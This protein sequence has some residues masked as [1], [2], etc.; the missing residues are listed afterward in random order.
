MNVTQPT[1]TV[2]S[3][4]E[5]ESDSPGMFASL[6]VRDFRYLWF[7][8]LAATFAMQMQMVARGWLI[9]DMTNSPLALTWVMLSFM[10]PMFLFSLAGG[11]IADRARKKWVMISA[12]VL[13]SVVT[14]ALA[15]IIYMGDVTFWHFIYFGVFN[16]TVLAVSMP[17]RSSIIPEIV[18]RETLVNA[19]AL[20]S[21]TF[22]LSR[23]LGPTLAG[24]LIAIV[25][26]GDTSSMRGVGIVYFTIA[27][28]YVLSVASTA[29]MH[30][31]GA[32]TT[33]PGKSMRGDIAE[34]FRYMR[35]ERL[36]LG[37]LILGFVPMT[38]GFTASFLLPA[39]N[40]DIIGGG[41]D[42]LGLL[43]TAMG[44]GALIGSLVLARVGDIGNKGRVM[45]VTAYLWAV[46]LAAFALSESL[47]TAMIFG[48]F[49]GLFGAIFGSLNMSIVQLA[50]RPEIRGRVMSIMMMAHGLMPIGVIPVSAAAE[51]I[52][53]DVALLGAAF[54]LALSMLALG[55]IFPELNKIDK[56]HDG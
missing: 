20:Q 26:S 8:N 27:G 4:Q 32:P 54:M 5:E 28:L 41:P 49:T 23:V 19:M 13:N 38:F 36:I 24:V 56:G 51:F 34:G 9:Y 50:I 48:A 53:I 22:N 35:E 30:Y 42:D 55:V 10:L 46:F 14:L 6:A 40:K 3:A 47:I 7:S 31:I 29:M 17:A 37:L 15:V 44:A 12:Q 1:D 16:G 11:V 33:A 2:D 21:A 43:L 52:G 45:F 18:P 39:F 25:A